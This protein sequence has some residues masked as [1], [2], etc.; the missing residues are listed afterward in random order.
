MF[1]VFHVLLLFCI[2]NL[3]YNYIQTCQVYNRDECCCIES[4]CSNSFSLQF[5]QWYMQVL[6]VCLLLVACAGLAVGYYWYRD[7]WKNH[8]LLRDLA[9]C[10]E[11]I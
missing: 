1:V 3:L 11:P 8:P 9:N 5:S 6:V 10:H 7:N 2:Q 4:S